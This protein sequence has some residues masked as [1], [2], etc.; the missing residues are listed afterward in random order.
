[1]NMINRV[2]VAKKLW[3]YLAVLVATMMLCTGCMMQLKEWQPAGSPTFLFEGEEEDPSDMLKQQAWDPAPTGIYALEQDIVFNVLDRV[4]IDPQSGQLTLIGHRDSRY[5]GYHIPYLQHLAEYLEHSE[6]KFSL[7]WT[8]ESEHAIDLFLQR[9]DSME[10]M[11]QLAASWEWVDDAGLPT[12][13]GRAFLPLFGVT[14]TTNGNSAGLLGVLLMLSPA[15][16]LVVADVVTDSP[17][18]RAGLRINDEILNVIGVGQPIHPI[19]M[20]LMMRTAGAGAEMK[21]LVGRPGEVQQVT[22]TLSAAPG[23]PWQHVDRFEIMGKMLLA[24][25]RERAGRAMQVFGLFNRLLEAGA[26]VAVQQ[27]AIRKLVAA[28][29]KEEELSRF[30]QR[31]T[32]E[33][34]S[35]PEYAKG[36]FLVLVN[37]LDD[38]FDPSGRSITA[39][40]DQLQRQGYAYDDAIGGAINHIEQLLR[41][42][43]EDVMRRLM[44]RHDE[45][46]VPSNVVAASAGVRPRVIPEYIDVDPTSQLARVFFSADY[47]GKQ[48]VNMPELSAS[49]PGY[50]TNFSFHRDYPRR[51]GVSRDTTTERMWISVRKLDLAQSR[52]GNTLVTKHAVMQFNIRNMDGRRNPGRA[53][54]GYENLLTSLYD[55]FAE[56]FPVLHE[57]RECAKLAAVAQW[58]LA[59]KPGL[60]LPQQG[61]ALWYGPGEVPGKLYLTWAPNYRPGVANVSVMA[62]GGVST[63]PPIGPAGPI[64]TAP[65]MSIIHSDPSVVDLRESKMTAMP[66]AFDNRVMAKVLRK[67][68]IPPLPNLRPAGWV[69]RATK[70]REK[71]QILTV[72]TD[73]TGRFK[74]EDVVLHRKLEKA[75]AA[76][77]RL[78]QSERMINYFTDKNISR[79]AELAGIEKDLIEGRKASRAYVITAINTISQGLMNAKV[80]ANTKAMHDDIKGKMDSIEAIH[81]ALEANTPEALAEALDK[82]T[83]LSK[84]LISAV[85]STNKGP[86]GRALKPLVRTMHFVDKLKGIYKG[87]N[88]IHTLLKMGRS[89][90]RLNQLDDP[91]DHEALKKIQEM[92][93]G[94]SDDVDAAMK[95]PDVARFLEGE[96]K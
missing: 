96:G 8:L 78:A 74:T 53:P 5:G 58:L 66:M 59:R 77:V 63:V 25:G 70:G 41:P 11:Q 50:Q 18:H 45:I 4:V 55:D 94:F 69:T 3:L 40:Y 20:S 88:Q 48:L 12:A 81:K 14:P 31:A 92:H 68:T 71:L 38:A 26:P 15:N 6:A 19:E 34:M 43:L 22:A 52:D 56:R 82:L 29:G 30:D 65:I 72:F 17:A 42:M 1:M 83:D 95:D 86:L 2:S 36:M 60:R 84:D 85:E 80:M 39:T 64:G 23:D 24:V 51:A 21:F 79:Q 73:E 76:A 10:Y 89:W 46:Q 93:R 90:R 37:G 16:K 35:Q 13:Y 28:C 91:K 7:N 33:G 9:M 54:S 57:L 47:L 44:R 49:I 67:K 62:T 75:R 87:A 27:S 32:R 61:R